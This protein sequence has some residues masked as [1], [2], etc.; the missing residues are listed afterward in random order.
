MARHRTDTLSLVFGLAFAAVGLILLA[1]GDSTLSLSW[2]APLTAIVLG[3]LLMFAARSS[4]SDSTPQAPE[5]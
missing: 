4:A 3:V 5:D 2:V 1:G